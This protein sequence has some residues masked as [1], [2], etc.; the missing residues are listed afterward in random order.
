[1]EKSNLCF[2]SIEETWIEV[3]NSWSRNGSNDIFFEN[4]ELVNYY[5]CSILYHLGKV[6]I[7]ANALS[8]KLAK[9]LANLET[10]GAKV[11]VVVFGIKKKKT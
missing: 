5:D 2:T 10:K 7:V 6:N 4:I 8:P 1:M 3:S 9:N 11:S